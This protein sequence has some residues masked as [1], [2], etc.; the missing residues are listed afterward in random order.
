MKI[1]P[2]GS[3]LVSEAT[4][5]EGT[6]LVAIGYKYNSKKAMCFVATQGVLNPSQVD[7]DLTW[8]PRETMVPV[9]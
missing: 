1:W 8:N 4:D 7:L 5:S 2:G 9:I 6:G 3:Y